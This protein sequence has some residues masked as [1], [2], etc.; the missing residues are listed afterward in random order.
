[1]ATRTKLNEHGLTDKQERTARMQAKQ[2]KDWHPNYAVKDTADA[3]GAAAYGVWRWHP[4]PAFKAKVG[5]QGGQ[6]YEYPL[7]FPDRAPLERQARRER[8]KRITDP[9][10]T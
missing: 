2:L 6:V 7:T 8:D 10:P 4:D 5:A 1:M 9:S 3:M